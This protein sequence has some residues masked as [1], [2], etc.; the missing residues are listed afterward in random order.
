MTFYTTPQVAAAARTTLRAIRLWDSKGMLGPVQRNKRGE[1][2]FN[3]DQ[4]EQAK[5]ISAA[6]MAGMGLDEIQKAGG[7]TLVSAIGGAR[8]FL[9]QVYAQMDKD[10]DL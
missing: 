7:A 6:S 1:R 10:F 2:L 8:I 9:K 5:I 3:D 4:L